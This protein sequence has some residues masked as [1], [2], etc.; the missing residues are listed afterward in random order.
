[1]SLAHFQIL[2]PKHG[3]GACIYSQYGEFSEYLF[4][5]S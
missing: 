1:M 4:Y 5:T 3:L 2:V